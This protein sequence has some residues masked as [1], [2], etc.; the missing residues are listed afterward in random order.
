M[1]PVPDFKYPRYSQTPTENRKIP[2]KTR[3]SY[4]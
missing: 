4:L 1:M 2:G 3:D